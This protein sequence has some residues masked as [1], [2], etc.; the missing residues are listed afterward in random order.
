[1]LLQRA[2]PRAQ[3]DRSIRAGGRARGGEQGRLTDA[4]R[5][6]AAIDRDAGLFPDRP[7][8]WQLL[9]GA[10]NRKELL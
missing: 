5:A 1:V 4:G 2:A 8:L 9:I 3:H 7:M 6:L 10:W